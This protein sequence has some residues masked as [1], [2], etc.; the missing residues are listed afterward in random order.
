MGSEFCD[1]ERQI[2]SQGIRVQ[3]FLRFV[4]VVKASDFYEKR[5]DGRFYQ[6]PTGGESCKERP[7]Q[8]FFQDFRPE[9]SF[10]PDL[11]EL[12]GLIVN[13][14]GEPLFLTRGSFHNGSWVG[15]GL[16]GTYPHLPPFY[17][18]FSLKGFKP[19]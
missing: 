1:G 19:S 7:Y 5:V 9:F 6:E 17:L 14:S 11:L 12:P 4:N 16:Y 18:T 15:R 13:S 8:D 3:L 10:R 2:N